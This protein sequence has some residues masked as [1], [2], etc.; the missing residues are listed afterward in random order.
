M[1]KIVLELDHQEVMTMLACTAMMAGDPVLDLERKIRA[2][3]DA[4]GT[5]HSDA[6]RAACA[7][8]YEYWSLL[9]IE[10]TVLAV[11]SR[12]MLKSTILLLTQ[13]LMSD[14]S[15]EEIDPG[16]F[17]ELLTEEQSTALSTLLRT[18]S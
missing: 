7:I 3:R 9:D 2:A 17:C 12:H 1:T 5:A 6:H 16:L 8:I 14:Y 11:R 10:D 4:T 15:T 18:V 13:T